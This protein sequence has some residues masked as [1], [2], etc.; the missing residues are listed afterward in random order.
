MT[1][2][3]YLHVGAPKAGTTYLQRILRSSKPTLAAQGVLVAG[4]THGDLV[5]AGMAVRED[6]RLAQ[7]PPTAAQ[8]W[9]RVTA[10]IHAFP[11]EIAIVS[12][13]LL[14]GARLRQV[15]AA[16][17]DLAG[18]EVH[19][20]ITGRD[21]GRAVSSA[22]Q[23]RLK[24][25]YSTPL[26]QWEPRPPSDGPRV[27]WGWRTI[28]PSEV[29]TRWGAPLPPSRVHIVTVPRSTDRP[30]LL[31]DRFSEAC[32]LGELELDLDTPFTDTA[33][34]SLGA[35]SA[36]VLRR[37]NEQDLGPITGARE[38]ARWL[39]DTLAHAVLADLDRDP[40][41][42]T[43]AQ[44]A[45]AQV[46]AEAAVRR[47]RTAG[48]SVHGDLGD[49]RATRREGRLPGEVPPEE[50]LDVAVKAIVS[51]LLELRTQRMSARSQRPSPGGLGGATA[52][53][54][55]WRRALAAATPGRS[56]RA[57]LEAAETRL[58]ALQEQVQAD[59]MLHERVAVLSDLVSELLLPHRLQD[60]AA[61]KKALLSYR[62]ASL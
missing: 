3:V 18:L 21:L 16:L 26:E 22:W 30:R 31:W 47:I 9:D 38:H 53:G 8:A 1:R 35:R 6:R 46:R 55:A 49:L 13:E 37:V 5:H 58:A 48:W 4:R 33:N 36:E 24:F 52:E 19:V 11:G 27:E 25:S 17:A 41:T 42:I 28:D 14:A 2:R 39:R 29:A 59:R 54:P 32:T 61:M 51:L 44:L 10:E 23:E 15:R 62:E 57:Q 56:T 45:Q 20:V 34:E 60:K 43:D 50:L 12:Y 7:L 40:I